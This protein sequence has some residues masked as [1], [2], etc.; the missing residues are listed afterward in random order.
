[1][2]NQLTGIIEKATANI[3]RQSGKTIEEVKKAYY[4]LT[5]ADEFISEFFTN[6]AF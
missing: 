6:Y 3:A 2:K 4:G 1:M 5:N